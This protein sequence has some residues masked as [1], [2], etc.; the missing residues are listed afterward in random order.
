[1]NV[2]EKYIKNL[3]LPEKLYHF[4]NSDGL[5]GISKNEEGKNKKE[6]IGIWASHIR[7]L[8]DQKEFIFAFDIIKKILISKRKG[9]S[10]YL[11]PDIELQR[12][13][14]LLLNDVDNDIEDI[15]IISFTQSKNEY[16]MWK[17][18]TD[19]S[20]GYCLSFDPKILS[21]ALSN[22][23]YGY[24][25][26]VVYDEKKQKELL[27]NVIEEAIAETENNNASN[28]NFDLSHNLYK[29]LLVIAPLLKSKEYKDENEC[30]IVIQVNKE[31]AS[32][33]KSNTAFLPYHNFE[34]NRKVIDEIT[35]GHCEN[36]E[37][38]RE[39]LG[40][41]ASMYLPNVNSQK[42]IKAKIFCKE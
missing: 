24:I 29:K 10:L 35:V 16:N 17:Q 12:A 23:S 38:L 6:N 1:M 5:L 30:R 37:Y 2:F 40:F 4:T 33:R 19:L 21:D 7:Y 13:I 27:D 42:V 18:Y 15:Y 14:A 34:I 41:L 11:K 28:P 22:F 26:S 31:N 32:I 3:K 20:P 8:K 9:K 36:F 25:A 39:S